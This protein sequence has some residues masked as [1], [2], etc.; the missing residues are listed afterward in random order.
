MPPRTV[1]ISL[2]LCLCATPPLPEATLVTAAGEEVVI[3]E[4]AAAAE[5]GVD[6]PTDAS[7]DASTDCDVMVKGVCVEKTFSY[8]A[9]YV[10]ANFTVLSTNTAD[11]A[12]ARSGDGKQG[13]KNWITADSIKTRYVDWLVFARP[14]AHPAVCNTTPAPPGTHRSR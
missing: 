13:Y 2:G 12:H 10:H 14:R 3:A 5:A 8:P 6:T 9:N 4:E 7:T 1:P 11:P